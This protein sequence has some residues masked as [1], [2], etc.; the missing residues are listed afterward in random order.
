M[1]ATITFMGIPVTETLRMMDALNEFID[2]RIAVCEELADGFDE[3]EFYSVDEF[4]QPFIQSVSWRHCV[5]DMEDMRRHRNN[6][7]GVRKSK[8]VK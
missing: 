6:R 7:I 2:Q 4:D 5:T 8:E 1:T 3:V